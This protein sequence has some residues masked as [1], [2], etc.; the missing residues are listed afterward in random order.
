MYLFAVSMSSL[1]NCVQIFCALFY[2]FGCFLTEFQD[3]H[4]VELDVSPSSDICFANVF[5][6][7]V[8]C[9]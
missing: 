1:I 7:S 2:Y 5:Y 9:I 4:F 8:G 6:H 3:L